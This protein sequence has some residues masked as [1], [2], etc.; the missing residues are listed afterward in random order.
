[1]AARLSTIL[2]AHGAGP[3]DPTQTPPAG[4]GDQVLWLSPALPATSWEE[5]AEW[6]TSARRLGVE[7]LLLKRKGGSYGTG[8]TRGEWGKWKVEPL[9][10][11]APM[12]FWLC[13]WS[14]SA[15]T[16]SRS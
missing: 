12:S 16:R 5:L 4:A 9:E 15:R 1:M 11:D 8:R 7:G 2:E 13:T 14:A 10:I 6:R 3:F